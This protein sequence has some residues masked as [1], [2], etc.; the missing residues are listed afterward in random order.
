MDEH[1]LRVASD[2]PDEI[3]RDVQAVSR[4]DA[5]P[6]L[7]RVIG[8]TTGMGFAAVARVTAGTW[9]ACAVYDNI[10]FNLKPGM[11]LDLH[12]TLCKEVREAMQ[13]VVIDQAS[14]DPV[15]RDHHTPRTYGIESY[16][17]VP[18]VLAD[19]LYFGNLCAIDPHPAKVSN[20]ATLSMFN[21]FAK[22]IALQLEAEHRNEA[23]E[24]ELHDEREL[25][26]LREQFIAVLGH[27]LRNPLS[28]ILACTQLLKRQAGNADQTQQLSER[29]RRNAM[30]MSALIDDTLDLARARLGP[31]IGIERVE[32]AD[33]A[34]LLHNVVAELSDARPAQPITADLRID[35][36]VT[37]DPGRIQQLVSN[38]LG[39][40]LGHGAQDRPVVLR[41]VTDADALRI[42]VCNEGEPIDAEALPQIFKPFWRPAGPSARGGGLGLGLYICAQIVQAHGGSLAVTSTH[43]GGTVFTVNLPL[44]PLPPLPPLLP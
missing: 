15:Y 34:S 36:P 7:L 38:L 4:I 13:P 8:E 41:A 35:R 1:P 14:L 19:G 10:A 21:S 17:S 3:A 44:P 5:V 9:T 33:L 2:A 20:P 29:V 22:L 11:Q 37:C 24:L 28:A 30:R 12:T 16:V 6:M 39:N 43:E 18:I 40:A 42:T 25:A 32:V 27:D 31:G 26:L 23:R